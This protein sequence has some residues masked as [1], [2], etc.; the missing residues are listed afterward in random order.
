MDVMFYKYKPKNY[1]LK[2]KLLKY[3]GI[4]RRVARRDTKKIFNP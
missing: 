4:R 1:Q 2:N 3:A